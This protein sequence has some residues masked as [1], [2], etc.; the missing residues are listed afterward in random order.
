MPTIPVYNWA[1][2]GVQTDKDPVQLDDAELTQAQNCI[3]SF[4]DVGGIGKRYGLTKVN[5]IAAA[6]AIGGIL[7]IPLPQS[8]THTLIFGQ[9]TGTTPAWNISTTAGATWATTPAP[10]GYDVN[11]VP[12]LPAKVWTSF[13]DADNRQKVFSGRPGVMYKNRLYYAGNDYTVGTTQPTIRVWDGTTDYLLVNIPNNP[14]TGAAQASAVLNMITAN[15]FIYLT[16]YDGGAYSNNLVKARVFQLD[17]ENGVLSQLGSRF[18]IS[19]ETARVPYAIGYHMGRVWTRT[20]TGGVSATAETYFIRP[21]ID[22]DWTLDV[23]A[24]TPICSNIQSFQGQLYFGGVADAG[25][26]ANIR[27]RSSVG[28]YSTALLTQLNEGGSVPVMANFGAYNHFGAMTVFNNALYCAYYNFEAGPGDRWCRVYKFDGTTWTIPYFPAKNSTT[29]YPYAHFLQSAGVL[30]MVSAP[31][32]DGIT[33]INSV[34]KTADGITWTDVSI[35]LTNSSTPAIG[36][37]IS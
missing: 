1:N 5:A 25:S 14:D 33:N 29:G 9:W 8:V 35:G 10:N 28:V 34:I 36:M 7:G 31:T 23:A 2:A 18:P 27:V 17:P 15:G 20:Y 22:V 6:G 26:A 24:A 16:T 11:A 19:P 4:T 13:A 32:Y 21:E 3:R 12:R 30:Y 37:I